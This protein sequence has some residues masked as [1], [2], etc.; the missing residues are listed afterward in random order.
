MRKCTIVHHPLLSLQ[1]EVPGG[2]DP[3]PSEDIKVLPKYYTII[4]N[5]FKP[6]MVTKFLI[7][8]CKHFTLVPRR[9][10]GGCTWCTSCWR[11]RTSRSAP[12]VLKL[13]LQGTRCTLMRSS[14]SLSYDPGHGHNMSN[15]VVEPGCAASKLHSGHVDC[16]EGWLQRCLLLL[17]LL[18]CGGWSCY[19]SSSTL[20][21]FPSL[22]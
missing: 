19:C 17:F 8:I 10:R 11:R 1:E 14:T 20:L 16:L 3:M 13:L 6:S 7:N 18:I 15:K 12:S 4:A 22:L 5:F 9:W 21:H 2:S